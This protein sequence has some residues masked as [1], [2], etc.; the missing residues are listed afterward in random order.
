MHRAVGLDPLVYFGHCRFRSDRE[1]HCDEGY[2]DRAYVHGRGT[3]R[4]I[5]Q[6]VNRDSNRG[7]R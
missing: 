7:F 2:R 1:R 5:T 3:M 6:D 4:R